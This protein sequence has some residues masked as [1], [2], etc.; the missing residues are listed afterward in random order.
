MLEPVYKMSADWIAQRSV[1]A[2]GSLILWCVDSILC[3]FGEP[4]TWLQS[5]QEG[6][7]ISIIKVPGL[8]SRFGCWVVH[9]GTS[10]L[11]IV[12]GKSN[13][14]QSMDL[15]LQLVEKYVRLVTIS[16]LLLALNFSV[17]LRFFL[18]EGF[19]QLQKLGQF[20]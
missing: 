9:M 5:L 15:L 4:A 8:S 16:L 11:P 19:W 17:L 18:H 2:H 12:S 7:T 20:Q 6:G 1:E 14:P 3:R 10:L 13:N